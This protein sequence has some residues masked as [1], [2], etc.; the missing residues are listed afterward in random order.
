MALTG[1]RRMTNEL[2]KQFKEQVFKI[3]YLITI[4]SNV[5]SEDLSKEL[6]ELYKLIYEVNNDR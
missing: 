3:L 5:Y 4:N 2:E 1:G 6:S